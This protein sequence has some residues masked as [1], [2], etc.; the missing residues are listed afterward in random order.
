MMEILLIAGGVVT[1]LLALFAVV[2]VREGE[3][4]AAT[5]AFSL[6]VCSALIASAFATLP[7][8][9]PL[10]GVIALGVIMFVCVATWWWPIGRRV[11]LGGRPVHRVDE[12]EIMF[13]RGRLKPG[14]AQFESYYEQHP[15]H[16]ASDDRTRALPGLLS[17]EAASAE[18]SVFAIAE[19]SFDITEALRDAV[20]GEVVST[21]IQH[22]S[23]RWVGEVKRLC[24]AWG[25]L[26]VGIT[27]LQPYHVYSNIGR[28]SGRWGDKIDLKHRWAVAFTVDM[29]H[30]VM[31]TAPDAPVVAESARRYVESAVIGIQL[32]AAI[33][34]W[35]YPARAHIDGNYR[36]IA[37]L[38]ARD[39][40]LGEIGRMGLLMT[41]RQGP[42]VRLG[43]VTTDLTLIA[44][45]PGDDVTALDF[46]SFCKKCAT[47]CPVGAIPTG[48]RQP[49]EG[50]IQWRADAEACFRYWNVIGTDCG[51]CMAVCPYSHPDNA[52]HNFVRW[53][54]SRSGG[55]RRA[56]LWMDN[57]FYGR[58][59]RS[60]T[61]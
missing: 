16:R 32:A 18:P 45:T 51:T 15:Q 3:P 13:A 55:A 14:S 49:I 39:A 36:V 10:I 22:S 59:H 41:P 26:D 46:C 42:R 17:L 40:G 20:D 38:V 48:D 9:A 61:R 47:S 2:S 35:G 11:A 56:M 6:S 23:E 31:A 28:G 60:R 8:P 19:A 21:Q 5:V 27:A 30:R 1:I 43:V 29:D 57:L 52:A 53:A 58:K 54:I 7:T 44:D 4:R 33:R 25:A 37:P 12:R 24:R 34:R 50:G